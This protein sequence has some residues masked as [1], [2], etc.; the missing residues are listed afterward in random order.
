MSGDIRAAMESPSKKDLE[1][2]KQLAK[3]VQ[4]AFNITEDVA[5]IARKI[6]ASID[7]KKSI[8]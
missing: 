7:E 3:A 5:D 2:L 4:G 8:K 1:L 6:S